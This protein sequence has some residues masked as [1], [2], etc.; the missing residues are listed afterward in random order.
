MKGEAKLKKVKKDEKILCLSCG[1]PYVHASY[2]TSNSSISKDGRYP[3]CK[4]CLN[5][6]VGDPF[7]HDNFKNIIHQME[8]PFFPEQYIKAIVESNVGRKASVLGMYMKQVNKRGTTRQGTTGREIGVRDLQALEAIRDAFNGGDL[9]LSINDHGYYYRA[10]SD[11]FNSKAIAEVSKEDR[12]R[13]HRWGTGFSID[14]MDKM[15]AFYDDMCRSFAIETPTHFKML[16]KLAKI[17]VLI[18]R[19]VIENDTQAIKALQDT[20]NKIT[21][22]AGFRPIDKISISEQAGIRSFSEIFA[23]IERDG[24]VEP[25]PLEEKKDII[26]KTIETILNHYRRL[27]EFSEVKNYDSSDDMPEEWVDLDE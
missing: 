3:I 19:A 27:N 21:A 1:N 23:E 10:G 7:D 18:D 4:K 26:D 17:D 9:D 25:Y 11:T 6:K 12:L 14:E 8:L 15:N 13:Y 5:E 22:D 2:Y 24:F 16:E 20:S